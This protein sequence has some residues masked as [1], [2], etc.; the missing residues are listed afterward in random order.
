MRLCFI[1]VFSLAFAVFTLC[2]A[3]ITNTTPVKSAKT[4]GQTILCNQYNGQ[5]A[6]THEAIKKLDE[7][8]EAIL[9][10]LQGKPSNNLALTC[11]D[12]YDKNLG[13]ENK[14]YLLKVGSVKIPVYC[15]MA[16]TGLEA[17]GGGGWTLVMK[18]DGTKKT[19]H[20]DSKFWTNKNDFNLPGGQT[21]LDLQETKLPTYWNT[22]FSKICLGMRIGGQ[23]KFT[24]INMH[25]NSLYSLIADGKYRA[26]SLGRN[27][28]KTLIGSKAS[29]QHNCNKEGF[30]AVCSSS[31]SSRA[32]IG[33]VGNNQNACSS[34]DS[35]I[36]FGTA[37]YPEDANTCGNVAKHGTDNGDRF[38]KMMGY[39]F[40]Q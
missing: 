40:V 22:P 6:K 13:K 9:K 2:G 19:F 8:I 28:W 15:H 38:I 37:G 32:R 12:L 14:A 10:L 39:I 18:I 4:D 20:F 31:G 16:T 7:K 26:T 35:R 27:T 29:L 33:F 17:C 30:N 36:G 11:K 23:I 24:V 34:C 21:G 3:K 25:A 1:A 5:D